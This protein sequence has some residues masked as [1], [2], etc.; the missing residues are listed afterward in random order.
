MLRPIAALGLALGL[1]A[2]QAAQAQLP[3]SRGDCTSNGLVLP[4]AFTAEHVMG[5]RG[6]DTSLIA[7]ALTL[8]ATQPLRSV[9]V[10]LRTVGAPGV[11]AEAEL[12]VGQDVRVGLGRRP[13]AR[14]SDFELRSSLRV[15]CMPA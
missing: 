6:G 9:T 2:S 1:F 8:R 15:V 5:A 4:G 11:S 3:P 14:L 7:Y 13:G 10:L 12:P